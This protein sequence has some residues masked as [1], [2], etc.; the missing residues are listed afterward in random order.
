MT[1]RFRWVLGGLLVLSLVLAACGGDDNGNGEPAPTAPPTSPAA[2][3]A[4]PTPGGSTSAEIDPAVAALLPD[5]PAPPDGDFRSDSAA[6]V[7]ATGRPQLL[8]FFTFW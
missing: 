8:E 2:T 1:Y 6:V 5:A 4:E 7:G 3:E